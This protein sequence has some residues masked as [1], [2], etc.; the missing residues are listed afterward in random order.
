M[1]VDPENYL[2]QSL[3]DLIKAKK[4]G[5]GKR[6]GG[7]ERSG[8]KEKDENILKPEFMRAL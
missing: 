4:K 6:G 5:G 8:G 1:E 7:P 2:S 3:D